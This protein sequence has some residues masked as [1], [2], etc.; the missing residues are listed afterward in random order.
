MCVWGCRTVFKLFFNRN[1]DITSESCDAII[2]SP[3]ILSPKTEQLGGALLQWSYYILVQGFRVN[4]LFP[5]QYNTKGYDTITDVVYCSILAPSYWDRTNTIE[6]ILIVV[7]YAFSMY[8]HCCVFQPASEC[9]TT[10]KAGWNTF[11]GRF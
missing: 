8:I 5:G 7:K 9:Y 3:R 11:L 4:F 10:L 6:L 2:A 1:L